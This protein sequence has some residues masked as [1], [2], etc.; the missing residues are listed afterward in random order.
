MIRLVLPLPPSTNRLYVR[1]RTTGLPVLSEAHRAYRTLVWGDVN[2][3]ISPDERDLSAMRLVVKV[4]VLRAKHRDLD[5]L[6]KCLLDSLGAALKFDDRHVDRVTVE[7]VQD[8][9]ECEVVIEAMGK[10][11]E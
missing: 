7:R 10:D 6:L 1:S 2:E 11:Q 3:Q 9:P 4:W 5:N 8:G